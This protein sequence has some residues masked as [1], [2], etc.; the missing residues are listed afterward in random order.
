MSARSFSTWLYRALKKRGIRLR[1]PSVTPAHRKVRSSDKWRELK[2][3]LLEALS[4]ASARKDWMSHRELDAL[5]KR[6][7][8]L[9]Q[10][11]GDHPLVEAIFNG[12]PDTLEK[13]APT[14]TA[15]R[16]GLGDRFSASQLEAVQKAN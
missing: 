8:G 9:E 14:F 13:I 11:E 7:E 10:K 4:A 12:T 16:L 1:R 15:D 3:V 5:L 6:I 2:E